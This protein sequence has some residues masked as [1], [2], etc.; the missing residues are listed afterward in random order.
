MGIKR[1]YG[2]G[3]VAGLGFATGKAKAEQETAARAFEAQERKAAQAAEFQY[4]DAIRQQDIVLDL[5]M[6]ERAK[7]WDIDKMELRSRMTF[8]E[9]EEARMRKIKSANNAL[10]QID[11]EVSAGR[12]SDKEAYPLK[13]KYELEKQGADAP[14]SLLQS[15]DGG[16][17]YGVKPWWMEGENAPEGSPMRQL[18]D[19]KL[20]EGISGDRGGTVPWDLQPS[21][22]DNPIAKASRENRGIYLEDY[23]DQ[24][25]KEQQ[26]I[27]APK[28]KIGQT[29][30]QGGKTYI[31]VGFD[32][33]GEPMV[34]VT[35]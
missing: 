31:V 6:R 7:R 26:Q 22:I 20:K 34:E 1:T 4:R 32:T 12:M 13:L 17:E 18:Y 35:K 16:Q 3:A 25:V 30:K 29:I 33:D 8:Q 24:R 28:Y 23:P 11:K 9:D 14:T 10:A 5:E 19:A 21:N 2:A 15:G 27:T